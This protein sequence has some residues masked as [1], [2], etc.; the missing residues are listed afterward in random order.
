MNE[1]SNNTN[2]LFRRARWEALLTA[3]MWCAAAAYTIG[4][5]SWF[6]YPG[7][8][9]ELRFVFG[10][11]NWVFWGIVVPWCV[12]VVVGCLFSFCV[13]KDDDLG[14]EEELSIT[15]ADG[16]VERHLTL[17]R[18]PYDGESSITAA[19]GKETDVGRN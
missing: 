13:M 1:S 16:K 8:F 11:P 3:L 14:T 7:S 15:A 5:C 12:C 18:S 10:F 6:G 17:D 2:T 4:Y 9:D 19:D